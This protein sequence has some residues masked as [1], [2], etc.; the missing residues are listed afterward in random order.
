M[1]KVGVDKTFLGISLV[2]VTAGIFIFSSASLGI[3]AQNE[4]KFYGIIFNQIILGL[5]S[6]FLLLAF[7]SKINYRYLKKFSLVVFFIGATLSA[8]V[9]VPGVGL[10]HNG[11][12]RW[13]SIG[14]FSFQPA[15]FL[16]IGF[17]AALA[18]I[19][20]M[21]KERVRSFKHGV[22]PFMILAGISGI[23][24]LKQP[25]TGTFLVIF[26]AGI[27]MLFVAGARLRDIFALGAASVAGI[28][29]LAFTKQY[30]MARILTF[31]NPS[32][33]PL[34]ASYQLQQ[35]LIAI[36]SGGMF[37]RGF[38][39]SIQ[40]FDFLP[41]PVGDSIFAVMSEEFGFVGAIILISL[42]VVFALRG[43][44]I[45][46]SSGDQFGRLLATGIVILIVSQSFINI[47]SM[48]GILPLTGV[49]IIF[50]SHGGTALMFALA[51]IGILLNISRREKRQS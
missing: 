7:F 48:I 9:F 45:A 2:I 25:D 3:L 38:G 34:G 37:G 40:K 28:V 26:S 29:A 5:F 27:A 32:E 21:F 23:I 36:G 1:K 14:S 44:K 17:V 10:E 20:S 41:E 33:D 47:G 8:L 43:L 18:A 19:L 22:L 51:E 30:L 15:E 16:K 50:V 24:L 13:I 11:A 39:Q 6:G 4:S 42:F 49:P 46:D 35:S 31:L 12:A